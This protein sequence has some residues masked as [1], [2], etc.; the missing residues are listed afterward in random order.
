MSLRSINVFERRREFCPEI[1]DLREDV[2]Y[3]GHICLAFDRHGNSLWEALERG[4]ISPARVRRAARQML[5]ALDRLHR[6]GYTHTDIKP[7]NIL[8]LPAFRRCPAGRP[9]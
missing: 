3:D 4:A 1:I 7:D 2:I 5:N 6:A 9:G 8:Y